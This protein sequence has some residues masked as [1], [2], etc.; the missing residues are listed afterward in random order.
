[1]VSQIIHD[2]ESFSYVLIYGHIQEK[3]SYWVKFFYFDGGKYNFMSDGSYEV[4]LSYKLY[5]YI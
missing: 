4:L 1:M 3:V 5:L 2:M